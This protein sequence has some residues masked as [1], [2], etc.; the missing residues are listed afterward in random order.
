MDNGDEDAAIGE[1]V[2][3]KDTSILDICIHIQI[4]Q[5]LA[6]RSKI[7]ARHFM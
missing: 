5:W 1:I 3:K 6:K 4:V 2:Q 7:G